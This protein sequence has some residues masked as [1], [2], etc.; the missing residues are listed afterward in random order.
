MSAA[1][2]LTILKKRRK[3]WWL[4][5]GPSREDRRAVLTG[6]ERSDEFI[7]QGK[8]GKRGARIGD[9]W[10]ARWVCLSPEDLTYFYYEEPTHTKGGIIDTIPIEEVV[11]VVPEVEAAALETEAEHD[12]E[13]DNHGS[14]NEEGETKDRRAK[15]RERSK[16]SSSRR[17]ILARTLS[18][19][20]ALRWHVCSCLT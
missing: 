1:V 20:F 4:H 16:A 12:A 8:L 11:D 17:D 18:Q 9:A 14:A 5:S 6:S 19:T 13:H 7:K 10:N 3:Q 15:F 2:L